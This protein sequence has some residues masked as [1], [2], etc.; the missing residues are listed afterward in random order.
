MVS[1]LTSM[2]TVEVRLS[3]YEY[4]MNIETRVLG[5]MW[6]LYSLSSKTSYQQISHNLEATR[7][8]STPK[9]NVVVASLKFQ[10]GRIILTPIQVFR[11]LLVP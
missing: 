1:F 7:Y 2:H 5:Q 4:Q 10:S 11:E 3:S 8:K 6:D 9:F